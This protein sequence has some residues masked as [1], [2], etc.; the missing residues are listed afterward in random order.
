MG[1]V[2]AGVTVAQDLEISVAAPCSSFQDL[3][4]LQKRLPD[5]LPPMMDMFALM[6]D[7]AL[8]QKKEEEMNQKQEEFE[9]EAKRIIEK[10]FD[11]YDTSNTQSLGPKACSDLFSH[12]IERQSRVLVDIAEQKEKQMGAESSDIFAKM[13]GPM[14]P[15]LGSH[16]GDKKQALAKIE[17]H[18]EQ[19]R[20]LMEEQV[21]EYKADKAKR[22]AAAL[23]LLDINGDGKLQKSEVV[24]GLLPLSAKNQALMQ[25]LGINEK[26]LPKFCIYQANQADRR[27]KRANE[28]Q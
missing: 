18:Y 20:R 28:Q 7:P 12:Y 10:C 9:A 5:Q 6:K 27:K 8:M 11:H 19:S 16:E 4:D 1:G 15:M 14:P 25:A 22:D 2:C 26:A 23:Q 24:E 17:E 13:M 21:V 3:V